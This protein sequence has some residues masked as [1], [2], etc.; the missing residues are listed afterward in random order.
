MIQFY[1]VSK[2]HPRTGS[3]VAEISF[4]LRKGE[5]TFLTGHSG[6]GKSTILKLIHFQTRPTK[7]ELQVLRYHSSR[8]K[9][10]QIPNLRRRVGFVFQDFKLLAGL[11]AAENVAFALKVTGVSRRETDRKVEQ[12]L[13]QVS[14]SEK[15][16]SLSSELSAGE[17]QRVVIAR[18]LATNPLLLL[19]DEPMGNLDAE[20]SEEIFQLFWRL[21]LE[22]MAVVMATHNTELV[23]RTPGVRVLELKNGQLISDS[24]V[25]TE[26]LP[27]VSEGSSLESTPI[28]PPPK[29][30]LS[31]SNKNPV[32]E[33]STDVPHESAPSQR[34][35]T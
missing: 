22:G 32:P 15:A 26:P 21:H 7:G 5:F 34:E 10:R 30:I 14:L 2:I 16:K 12:L 1:N 3:A 27:S 4:H 8:T 17:K 31:A 23:R 11:T 24:A 28:S 19:A 9:R 29:P 25:E 35:N 18:A 13:N 20:A 6:A 33:V